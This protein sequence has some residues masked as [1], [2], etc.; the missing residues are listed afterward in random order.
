MSRALGSDS[1]V[2]GVQYQLTLEHTSQGKMQEVPWRV[3][4]RSS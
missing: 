1:C 3:T 2:E 4:R